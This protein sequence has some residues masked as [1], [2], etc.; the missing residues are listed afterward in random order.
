[1]DDKRYAYGWNMPGYLP[2]WERG[3]TSSFEEAKRAIIDAL[4]RQE[5]DWIPTA[6]D[7]REDCA[8]IFCHTAEDVNLE[9]G[10]FTT[11][12]M[13]DGNVYWVGG[14]VALCDE[15]SERRRSG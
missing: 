11:P 14:F 4:K 9:S 3:I 13:P 10:P 7:G 8:E 1:M 2:E 5:S 6:H 15:R 12:V